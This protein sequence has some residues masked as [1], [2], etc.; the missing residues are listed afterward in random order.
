MKLDVYLNFDGQTEEAFNL[1]KSVF[2]GEFNLFKRMHEAPGGDELSEED[3]NRIMHIALPL[4]GGSV[5]RGSDIVSSN[6]YVL[7]KGNNVNIY[8][9]VDSK[10]EA[11]RIIKGLSG[12]GKVQLPM[13]EEFWGESFGSFHDRFGI[14]WMIGY[15]LPKTDYLTSDMYL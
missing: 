3:R 8:I 7:N 13:M 9:K 14:R 2:G 15:T 12:G 10:R 6:G 1:Y 11:D 4:K 5:L